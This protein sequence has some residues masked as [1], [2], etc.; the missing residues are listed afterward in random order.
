MMDGGS[1]EQLWY[2][3]MGLDGPPPKP[4]RLMRRPMQEQWEAAIRMAAQPTSW[5]RITHSVTGERYIYCHSGDDYEGWWMVPYRIAERI[6]TLRRTAEQA[7]TRSQNG[8]AYPS[9]VVRVLRRWQRTGQWRRH[10]A[11]VHPRHGDP[12]A[13]PT[14]R[15]RRAKARKARLARIRKLLP[16]RLLE[17]A[18]IHGP[19]AIEWTTIRRRYEFT[20]ADIDKLVTRAARLHREYMAAQ[21]DEV[22][23]GLPW[24]WRVYG[25]EPW[26]FIEDDRGFLV[27]EEA[28]EGTVVELRE[29]LD[30]HLAL[31]RRLRQ[32]AR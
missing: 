1:G 22:L 21:L 14:L 25:E 5:R 31:A 7:A 11:R 8:A 4:R 20:P 10:A 9:D 3:M 17:I 27:W 16:R 18:R 13:K 6:Q 19:Q 23:A 2:A 32:L 15:G 29:V 28:G 26:R 24:G 12:R 30:A